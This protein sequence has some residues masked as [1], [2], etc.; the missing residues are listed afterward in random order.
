MS[1]VVEADALLTQGQHILN[2]ILSMAPLAVAGVMAS[3]DHGFD[4]SLT[5][6]LH[7]EAMHFANV[8]ATQDKAEGVAAFLAKRPALFKGV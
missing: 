4:M 2:G 6:A 8:C 5:D 7:L 1:E 3:I